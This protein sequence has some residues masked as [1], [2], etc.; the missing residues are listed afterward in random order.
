MIFAA[1]L[2]TRLAP[3][4]NDRPKAMVELKGKSLLWHVTEKLV[5]EGF[6]HITINTHHFSEKINKYITTGEY[7]DYTSSKGITVSISD[8]SEL[9]LNTGGGLRKASTQL[10]SQDKTPVLIHNVDILSNANL[11]N[12]YD[13]IGTADALLLVSERQTTRYLLFDTEMRMVGWQNIQTGEIKTPYSN[14]GIDKCKRYAFSGIHVIT[15]NLT[16]KMSDWPDVFGITD[17][18][19]KM[20]NTLNIRA[21]IQDN[22]QLVDIGKIDV[23]QKLE[24][25]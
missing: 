21:C 19:I 12:L 18:Y 17:F 9:L 25:E 16:D 5:N 15:K 4:T 20:C 10:F 2:G 22:L 1:G 7:A 11:S 6:D 13:A 8:E 3:L 23:L 14:L 24:K